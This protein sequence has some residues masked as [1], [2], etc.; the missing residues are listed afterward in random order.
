MQVCI[1]HA[2]KG[3]P[4]LSCHWYHHQYMYEWRISDVLVQADSIL[5]SNVTIVRFVFTYGITFYLVSLIKVGVIFV[6]ICIQRL[7]NK[8]SIVAWAWRCI[9]FHVCD[10]FI[11][12]GSQGRWSLLLVYIL[13]DMGPSITSRILWR[14]PGFVLSLEMTVTHARVLLWNRRKTMDLK[15][16]HNPHL[17]HPPIGTCI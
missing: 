11:L 10:F 3:N 16:R 4:K 15:F 13:F 14:Q 9:T 12:S 5:N 6:Y 17:L 2:C 1:R 8:Q 7:R